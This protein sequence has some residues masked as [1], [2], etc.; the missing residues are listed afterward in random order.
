MLPC[1]STR[2]PHRS[3]RSIG[4]FALEAAV[5]SVILYASLSLAEV[6]SSWS[7]IICGPWGCTAPL[8]A[9]V[10]CHLSW[11]IVMASALWFANRNHL[12]NSQRWQWIIKTWLA[13]GLLGVTFLTLRELS[14]IDWQFDTPFLLQRIGL[15][16]IGFIDMP[17]IPS[18]V[19]GISCLIHRRWQTHRV[20]PSPPRM[21]GT[22]AGETN[23]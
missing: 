6:R 23:E 10:S 12:L 16:I 13:F 8:E 7:G 9:V 14:S 11:L 18:L 22:P 15:R 17:V 4:I 1:E 21:V 19:A 5:W 3:W 20:E 2:A